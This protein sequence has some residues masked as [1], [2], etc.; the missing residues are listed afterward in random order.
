MRIL[1]SDALVVPR[2]RESRCRFSA[3]SGM[4]KTPVLDFDTANHGP[5]TN[6]SIAFERSVL[7]SSGL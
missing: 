1:S 2:L 3:A 7:G 4:S 5:A 6:P